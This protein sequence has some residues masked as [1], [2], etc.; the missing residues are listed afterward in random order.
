MKL[1]NFFFCVWFVFLAGGGLEAAPG[2]GE[3]NATSYDAH[4]V[5]TLR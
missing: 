2:D 1:R 3:T 5:S 4:G